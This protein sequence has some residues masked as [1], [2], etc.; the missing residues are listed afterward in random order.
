MAMAKRIR[1][2]VSGG[3][4]AS[5]PHRNPASGCRPPGAPVSGRELALALLELTEDV[6]VVA[7]HVVRHPPDVDRAKDAE[8]ADVDG[9]GVGM[10]GVVPPVPA[11]AEES[12]AADIDVDAFRDVDV[13]VAEGREDGHVRLREVD[14]GF[15]QIE[16][17]VTEGG[18]RDG[19]PAQPEPPA[20]RHMAEQGRGEAG[21]LAA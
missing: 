16:V 4:A 5:S 20:P 21:G 14:G 11:V 18:C 17:E 13:D 6:A 12:E 3:P 10:P 1:R 7:A 15:A 2:I 19:P 9:W 8:R